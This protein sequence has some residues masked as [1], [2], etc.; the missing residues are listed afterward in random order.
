MSQAY[1]AIV[2]GAGIVGAAC[3]AQFAG[4]GLR[5]LL[6]DRD[7]PASGATGAA[8][9]H[10]VAMDNSAAQ[11][12][13]TR[14]SQLLWQEMSAALPD[15]VEYAQRGTLWLAADEAEMEEVRRKHGMYAAAWI[16]ASVLDRAALEDAEP[17]LR[18]G[19]RGALL[20]EE[21]AVISPAAATAYL[22]AEAERRGTALLMGKRVTAVGG[23][24]VRLEDGSTFAAAHVVIANGVGAASLLPWLPIT[25]RKGHLILTQPCSGFAHRQLVELGYLQSAH[26]VAADSVAFNVQP[27]RNGQLLIG[28]SRQ[29]HA[30]HP[31][32]DAHILDAMLQRAEEYMPGVS[33]LARVRAWTGFRAA[34]PDKLPLIGAVDEDATLLLAAGHEGLGITTSLATARLLADAIFERACAIDATPYLPS[35]VAAVEA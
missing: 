11:L 34:T 2:V 23:G 12:A 30:E 7:G 27:R 32:I 35:R 25:A 24:E 28:S 5:V 15:D 29:Y 26:A 6:V 4:E 9:G 31:E 18:R 20:V 3:A 8:M 22:V 21:D 16:P 13:L 14:Y 17:H 33:A 1:D 19:L 10:I